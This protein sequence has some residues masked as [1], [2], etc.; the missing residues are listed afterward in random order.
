LHEKR[1]I[2]NIKKQPRKRSARDRRIKK[3]ANKEERKKGKN[4]QENRR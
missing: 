3:K 1:K 4:L 2:P